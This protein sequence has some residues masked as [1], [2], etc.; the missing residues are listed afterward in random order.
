MNH[1][2]MLVLAHRTREMSVEQVGL[3][4]LYFLLDFHHLERETEK[5]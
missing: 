4:Q 1:D 5:D 2:G 3:A